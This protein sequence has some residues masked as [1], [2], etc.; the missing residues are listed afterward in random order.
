MKTDYVILVLALTLAVGNMAGAALTIRRLR[1]SNGPVYDDA[2]RPASVVRFAW[3]RVPATKGVILV[4]TL[5]GAALVGAAFAL[6][7]FISKGGAQH[8]LTF[9]R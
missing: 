4:R 8:L 7:Q 3:L 5:E 1:K 6:Y 2:P 9:M